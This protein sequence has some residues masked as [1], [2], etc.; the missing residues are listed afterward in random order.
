[1]V[2]ANSRGIR[3]A[4]ARRVGRCL[5]ATGLDDG[6]RGAI[7][8]EAPDGTWEDVPAPGR[9]R[10]TYLADLAADLDGFVAVGT[11]VLESDMDPEAGLHVEIEGSAWRSTDLRS[12]SE[13][14]RLPGADPVRVVVGDGGWVAAG[15]YAP[16]G[17]GGCWH[18]CA[19]GLSLWYSPDGIDW[20]PA[21]LEP[22]P[23]YRLA[24]IAYSVDAGWLA[25]ATIGFADDDR[26]T[27]ATWRSTDGR[28]WSRADEPQ[29]WP[30]YR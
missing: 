2:V 4:R 25:I 18:G 20:E 26:G 3:R 21:V 23:A 9:W 7:W 28:A 8:L 5:G 17:A 15:G 19:E 27:V 24:G 30:A 1:M 16:D 12:W 11:R 13:V 29:G 14:G 10:S 6:W 22:D